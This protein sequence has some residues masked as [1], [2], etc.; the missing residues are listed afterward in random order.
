MID[1]QEGAIHYFQRPDAGPLWVDST[2]TSLSGFAGR[3]TLNKQKGNWMVNSALGV[4]DPGFDVN[5]LGFQFRGDQINAS[6]MVGHKWT[7]PGRLMRSWR[8]NGAVFRNYNFGGDLT[9]SGGFLTGVHEF[10][11]FYTGRWSLV[12]N[13]ETVSDRQSRGGPLM[14][15]PSGVEWNVQMTTDPNRRWVGG[16]N[17]G[18]THYRLGSDQ[19][20]RVSGSLEW[21]PGSRVSLRLEPELSRS[22]TAAQYVDTFD[23]PLAGGT[24]GHRYV[25]AGLDQTTLASS[26]RLNWI[27]SPQLSLEV[28]AQPLLSAGKYAG[29]KELAR[30]RSYDFTRY[31]D[32]TPTADPDRIVVD[33]DGPGGP[34]PAQEIDDPN[35]SL[36]SLRGNAVLRWEYLPGSTLFLVWTQNRSDTQTIGAFDTGRSLHRLFHAQADNIFLVKVSYWWNP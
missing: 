7:R 29:F 30:A 15:N 8:L 14:L 34:A 2:A 9:W 20:W 26:V 36:A 22:R 18:G 23:D 28:Y 11:N 32:P 12:Y 27:F 13:P 25:F 17:L 24:F 31:P 1:L 35:F 3:I 19:T 21:K 4:V 33:P 16:I 6:L 10:T 5:D